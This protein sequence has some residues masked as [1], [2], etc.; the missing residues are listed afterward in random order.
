MP[1]DVDAMFCGVQTFTVKL[2]FFSENNSAKKV[3]FSFSGVVL[4]F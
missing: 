3:Q 4:P 1:S 2:R